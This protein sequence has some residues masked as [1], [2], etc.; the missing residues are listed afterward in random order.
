LR[1][2][3]L[4][5]SGKDHTVGPPVAI[6]NFEGDAGPV[7]PELS[8]EVGANV[9]TEYPLGLAGEQ[10]RNTSWRVPHVVKGVNIRPAFDVKLDH[11]DST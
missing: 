6:S 1:K 5:L 7:G 9:M 3:W 2:H 11:V 4:R 10:S 8:H